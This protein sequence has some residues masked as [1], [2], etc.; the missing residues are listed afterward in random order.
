M[1]PEVINSQETGRYS[2]I[3]S[4]GCTILE[5]LTGEPPWGRF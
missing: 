3:W 2:D 4:L 5:M 1:A